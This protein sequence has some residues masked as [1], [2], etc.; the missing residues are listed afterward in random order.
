MLKKI[1]TNKKKVI[2]VIAGLF[3]LLFFIVFIMG[4]IESNKGYDYQSDFKVSGDSLSNSGGFS[5][6]DLF[7]PSSSTSNNNYENGVRET[8][9]STTSTDTTQKDEKLVYSANLALETK[10]LNSALEVIYKNIEDSNGI[11]QQEEQRNYGDTYY[12]R[13]GYIQQRS[14]YIF[15]RVPSENYDSFISKIKSADNVLSVSGLTKKVE[16]FTDVYSDLDLKLK[17]YKIQQDRLFYFLENAESIEDM[18]SIES[19]LTELQYKIESIEND[20]KTI[21]KDVEYSKI[22]ITLTEVTKY[23]DVKENPSTFLERLSLYFS[24]SMDTFIYT[25]EDVLEFIIYAVPYVI[26]IG[27]IW[28]LIS[29]VVKRRRMKNKTDILEEKEED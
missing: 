12:I 1:K 29:K 6:S 26:I 17:N 18:L 3:V 16:N 7:S 23:T 14:S 9:T 24:A 13:D 10:Q 4:N 5:L 8:V 22:E 20:M 21:N 28:F 2:G 11:I 15:V 27:V 19:N 25:M